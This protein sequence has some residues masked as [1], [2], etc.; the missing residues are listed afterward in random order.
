MEYKESKLQIGLAWVFGIV[1]ATLF[2]MAGVLLG[3]GLFGLVPSTVTVFQFI[4]KMRL[5]SQ[6]AQLK[7]IVNWWNHYQ[8]NLKKYWRVSGLFGSTGIVLT[9]NYL[10]L[11]T[12]T[13]Y[14]TYLAFYLTLL[15]F[16]LVFFVFLWFSFLCSYYP[17]KSIKEIGKNA[18]AYPL[19]FALEMLVL[20]VLS[21]AVL[22]LIWAVTPGMVVF[23]GVGACFVAWHWVFKK[24]H[25]TDGRYRLKQYWYRAE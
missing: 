4:Q 16:V 5:D 18:V 10:F 17:E 21:V 25:D 8:M 22:M 7:L 14:V 1:M 20:M 15:M 13:N 24:L 12:Q 9:A 6:R 3:A 23:T 2:W 11:N 19:A